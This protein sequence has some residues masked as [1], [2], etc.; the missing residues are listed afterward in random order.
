MLESSSLQMSL[1]KEDINQQHHE[2]DVLHHQQV[3]IISNS[4]QMVVEAE[5][6]QQVHL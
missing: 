2:P 3:S 4:D 6:V 5:Q 1:A